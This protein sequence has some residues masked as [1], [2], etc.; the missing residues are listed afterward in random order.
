MNLMILCIEQIFLVFLKAKK[1]DGRKD[2]KQLNYTIDEM[3]IWSAQ[4]IS[5]RMVEND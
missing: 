2:K 4:Y 5:T 1:E 3:G